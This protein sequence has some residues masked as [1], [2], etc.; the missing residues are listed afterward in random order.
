MK[1]QYG[2]A[3]LS[4]QQVYE[5]SR[6]FWNGVS[7]VTV[8]PWPGQAHR[9]VT[10]ELIAAVER[11]V[12]ENHR[13]MVNDIATLL[14]MSHGSAHHITHDVLQFHKVSAKWVPRQLTPELTQRYVDACQELLWCFEAEGDDFLA[15]IVT[16]DETWVYYHQLE[17]KKAGK[18]WCHPSSPKLKTR[19]HL[20]GRLWW[21]SF[22][23]KEASFWST[24]CPGGTLSPVSRIQINQIQTMW[25]SE[26]RCLVA[27]W[28]CSAPYCLFS[29]CNHRGPAR[30]VSSTPDLAPS[31]YHIFRPLREA[32]GGKT[33]RS[34]EEVQQVVHE[35]LRTRPKDFFL[36]ESMHFIS[37]GGLVSNAME[38]T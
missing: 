34:D 18:E 24:T 17:T 25:T 26:Y 1:V 33:L 20:Q 19:S 13:V 14:D 21:P 8:S 38:T 16:G 6:K 29:S 35:W 28:Q 32:M 5:W 7:F 31:D 23:M 3:C 15:R 11:I 30:R 37:A 12:T 36:E 9:I 10:S 4:L 27:A 22:G 2:V